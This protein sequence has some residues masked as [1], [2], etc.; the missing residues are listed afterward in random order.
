[1]FGVRSS[2]TAE[3]GQSGQAVMKVYLDDERS[4]LTGWTLVRWP[5]EVVPLLESGEVTAVSSTGADM[6]PVAA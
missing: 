3:D 1:M 6:R 4:P 5:D 2:A